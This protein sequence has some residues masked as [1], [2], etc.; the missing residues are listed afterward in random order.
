MTKI[1]N[2]D[3]GVQSQQPL[4]TW[5]IC[6]SGCDP[7]NQRAN[8]EAMCWITK[9][10]NSLGLW[11]KK[12]TSLSWGTWDQCCSNQQYNDFSNFYPQKATYLL[13]GVMACDAYK[14]P[15]IFIQQLFS[16]QN[17]FNFMCFT[18]LPFG[19]E[20]M[21]CCTKVHDSEVRLDLD[22]DMQYQMRKVAEQLSQ[23]GRAG[24]LTGTS[25]FSLSLKR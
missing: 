5:M 23:Q 10:W 25:L 22:G 6:E 4:Q 24:T 14:V 3:L 8:T 11:V 2:T 19:V 15:L 12:N 17:T 20:P 21:V 13:L 16:I 7:F 1:C 18:T 9:T